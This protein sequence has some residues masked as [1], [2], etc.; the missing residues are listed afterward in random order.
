[1]EVDIVYYSYFNTHACT[2]ENYFSSENCAHFIKTQD[3]TKARCGD[4]Y[5]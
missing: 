2:H 4:V 5:L 3:T 1:M